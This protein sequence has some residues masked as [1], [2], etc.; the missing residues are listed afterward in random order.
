M[1]GHSTRHSRREN[2]AFA[3]VFVSIIAA[4]WAGMAGVDKLTVAVF[5]GLPLVAGLIVLILE[6]EKKRKR[7]EE[8]DHWHE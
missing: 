4:A 6:G 7:Q 1:S 3:V 5:A 2:I 8:L